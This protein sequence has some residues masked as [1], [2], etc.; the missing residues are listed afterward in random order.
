MRTLGG[1]SRRSLAGIMSGMAKHFGLL[2]ATPLRIGPKV[3]ALPRL[4]VAAVGL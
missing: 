4:D 1:W 2:G 3:L